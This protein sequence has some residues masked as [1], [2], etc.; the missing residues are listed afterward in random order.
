MV[1]S[2]GF[3]QTVI[4]SEDFESNIGTWTQDTADTLD[5]SRNSGG[6]GSGGTGPNNSSDGS[7][8][9]YTEASSNY[10]TTANFIS[11]PFNLSGISSPIFTF[12]Y[13][14]FGSNMGTLN[15]NISTDGGSTFGA[16]IWT[17]NGQHQGSNSAAWQQVDI[18]LS[19]Y[20]GQTIN[21]QFNGQVGSSYRS[22]IAID[23]ISLTVTSSPDPEIDVTGNSLPIIGDGTNAP[24]INDNTDFGTVQVGSET[25]IKTYT[26]TNNGS[27]DLV[28]GTSTISGSSDFVISTFPGT[29][30]TPGNSEIIEISFN[31]LSLGIQTAQLSIVNN[32]PDENPYLINL[33]AEGTQAFYDSDGDGVFDDVDIDDDNDG[34]ID[35][36]EESNCSG[37]IITNSVNY[38]FLNET[39]G[40]G[41]RT[42]I[43]TS[44]N[45]TTTYCYEDGTAGTDTTGCPTLSDTS[46]NDGEYTVYSRITNND[47]VADGIN[48]DIA[49][50]AEDFWYEGEDH[51][52][53]DIDG[54]MAI[55]NAS[56]DPGVFYTASITG[57]LPNVPITY[58]FWVLNIDRTDAPCV[59][60]GSTCTGPGVDGSRLRPNVLVE[61]RDLTGN[62]L[63]SITTGDIDPTPVGDTAG[64][65]MNFR[66]D[67][68]LN[69]SQFEVVFINNET[70]G[71]GNDLALDDIKIEQ[72]LCDVDNDGIADVFD[73]DSDDD[74]IVDLIEVGLGAL[75]NGNGVIDPVVGWVDVNG[76]GLHDAAAGNVIP[77]TDGDGT[78]DYLD[79]DSDNDS[80]FDVDESGATNS[81]M[82]GFINE[83]GD[84]NGDGT[85]NNTETEAFREKDTDGDGTSEYYGDGILDIYEH[86]SGLYGNANQTNPIDSDGDTIPDYLDPTTNTTH[87]ISTTLYA[88]LDANND[89]IIDDTIDTDGDGILDLYDTDDMLFGSPRDL[90]RSLYI[91]FDGRNDYAQDTSLL[92]GLTDA[93]IMA[94]INIDDLFSNQGFIVGQN[95]FNLKINNSRNLIATA[96]GT[97]LSNS[98]VLNTSQWIHVAAVYSSGTNT[99]N[100]YVN[101]EEVNTTTA[102]SALNVDSSLLTL[103]KNPSTDTE[104]F[105]GGIEEVKIFGIA[106]T[107]LQLQKMVYQKIEDNG[108]ILGEII[109]IDIDVAWLD[110]LRYYRMDAYQDD[111][112]DNYTTSI[113]DQYP[114]TFARCYNVKNIKVETAPMPFVTQAVPSNYDIGVAVSQNN[115]VRGD[116]VKDYDWSI[117][118]IRHDINL[119]DFHSDLGLMID[120]GVLVNLNNDTALQNNW[121]LNLDG[122][123][124]LNGESQLVQTS[125]SIL[126]ID[127]EGYI[128]RDQQ[129]TANSFTYNYWSSPVSVIGAGVN[130]TPFS[131]SDVLRDGTTSSTPINLDFDTAT[132]LSTADPYYSDGALTNPRKIASYWLWKFV[133]QTNDYANWEWFGAY[134]NINVADGFSMKGVSS[135]SSV[136]DSQNYVFVGKPN[137]APN[138][139]GE[140]VHTTFPG[141]TSIEGYTYNSLTGNPFPSAMDADQFILDNISS[142]TGTIYFWEHWGGG[143][144]NWED[145]RAG[146]SMYTMSGGLPGVSHPDGANVGGGT[147]TPGQYIPVGQGFYIVSSNAG[148]DVV[149]KNSQRIFKIELDDDTNSDHSIFTRAAS[150]NNINEASTERNNNTTNEKQRIRLGFE[151]PDGYHRQVLMAFLEGAT[152]AID[153][154]YD[155]EAGDYLP[156]DGFF[157]QDDKYYAIIAFGEFDEEREVPISIFIDEAND[158]GNQK[159]M[160]DRIENMPE[161]ISIYIKDNETG[162]L[163]DIKNNVFEVALSTG[164]H[165]TRFSVV[166][167]DRVL[168][169]NAE[170]AESN[171]LKVFMNNSNS[172]I[173][174]INNKNLELNEISLYNSIGQTINSWN[175]LGNDMM[176]SLPLNNIS[177]GVYIVTIKTTKGVVSQKIIIK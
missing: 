156:N 79:L 120:T 74:G 55:F 23:E 50:W 76:D 115:D 9:M 125:E 134:N 104:Y 158:G 126:D 112:V 157:I 42:T 155:G 105:N 56:Y 109:P 43:N 54:R 65:W 10:N 140:I 51:T 57:A 19:T 169:L 141:G 175:H 73:L 90:D 121:Y 86:S 143:N 14:M 63:A 147:K 72:T 107:E 101:G 108:Q 154:G 84:I 113:I 163:H 52:P 164:E 127:S 94:W 48:V 119:D 168:S 99:F 160:V 87:D 136:T 139:T 20:I 24:S 138:V 11:E 133:N 78:P 173:Q 170:L 118:H 26:I 128:E 97:T 114:G 103:A 46:L 162:I 37:S 70:G 31:T 153:P 21:I 176:I 161:T 60:G 167:Q 5:W 92:G 77:D 2:V 95:N 6:T 1:F 116:D 89:G 124:D 174:I 102:A 32:D 30:I 18:D 49:S 35:S 28:L 93:T 166:F 159:F 8:Y 13:H 123:V 145:Y 82:P 148:G 67:L 40:T 98:T 96:N 110:L 69:V 59:D 39:F 44:Y 41:G 150:K 71:L 75:N 137:N 131:I 80:I 146:Y 171:D 117:T 151:S 58:D 100:L 165:K 111:V 129:G 22:D 85:G 149:F 12:H 81:S 34:I 142:T 29:T 4:Y 17:Q 33:S 7:F 83:D 53:G 144:H 135:T 45:A 122:V 152:D 91:D 106:L 68:V 132:T 130:N 16:P 27:L 66:A 38:K 62:V 61:F 172:E 64:N 25:S 15:V 88:S 3:S 36:L 47:D 177:S